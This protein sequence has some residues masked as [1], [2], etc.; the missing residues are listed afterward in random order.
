M[1]VVFF[2]LLNVVN[3][4]ASFQNHV[5]MWSYFVKWK[6]MYIGF[7]YLIKEMGIIR[8]SSSELK[9]ELYLQLGIR[10]NFSVRLEAA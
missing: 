9:L 7:Y 8:K 4:N 6:G 5:W 2:R 1:A 3:S 10:K